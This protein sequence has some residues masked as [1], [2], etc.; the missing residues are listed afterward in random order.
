MKL[1]KCEMCG[2][3]A[4]II[5]D[6]ACPTKCC[7]EPMAELVPNT[8]DG[9]HEKHVPVVAIDGDV[10]TVTVGEAEH[11]ML[12]AHYI[13]WIMLE[14]NLGRARR[15]LTPGSAPRAQ[16][17]LAEDEKPIAA[18]EYCNLHGFWKKEL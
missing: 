11:P 6:S 18:Y 13:Q 1:V 15:E 8:S 5:Q 16:F 17:R 12:D 3:I 14:T 2:K 4:G 10:V 9:A 7:G